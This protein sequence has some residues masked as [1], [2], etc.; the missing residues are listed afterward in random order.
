[1]K[2]SKHRP[3]K[4]VIHRQIIYDNIKREMDKISNDAAVFAVVKSN[5]YGHGAIEI[6]NIA[7]EAG[8]SGFCVATLD[9]AL[10]L[11]EARFKAPI[12]ILG[13]V[14]PKYCPILV[15]AHLW[16]TVPDITW[17]KAAIA[18]LE[19]AD[20]DPKARL[21]L[22]FKI[23]TGMGRLGFREESEIIEAI[24]LVQRHSHLVLDGV[25]THFSKAD[26][27]DNA[28]LHLQQ[29][30]FEDILLLFPKSVKYVHTANSSVALWHNHW[31][32][33]LIRL[34]AVIYGLNPSG[35]EKKISYHLDQAMSLITEI[36][37]VKKVHQGDKIGYG[38][39]YTAEEDQWIATLP[40]GYGDG[41]VRRFNGF[42]VLVD[43]KKAPIIGRV[44][45][46][47]CMIQLPEFYPVG[48]KV[49]IFG[50]N[51][52]QVNT[53]QDGA[54]HIGTINYE[55]PCLL[56]ERIEKIYV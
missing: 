3:T 52:D 41:F 38:A 51:G 34:G 27:L 2:P 37:H 7:Q 8:V 40:I 23:D 44:C 25:F 12:L 50:R 47:Q 45:M 26:S 13:V 56:N 42:N 55:I 35:N 29:K 53:F 17:L 46:D 24:D 9:E 54:E 21:Y 43:G 20:L 30:R 14:D 18:A 6:S 5:A 39:E 4:A 15:Q 1:M 31:K 32:S 16:Q 11:R 22:H 19:N 49:T 33:N 48:T 28:Y 10:E 36:I